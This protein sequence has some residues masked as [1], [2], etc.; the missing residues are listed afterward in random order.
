MTTKDYDRLM[1]DVF[2]RGV[3][4]NGIEFIYTYGEYVKKFE[5]FVTNSPTPNQPRVR[6]IIHKCAGCKIRLD[7]FIESGDFRLAPDA[8]I[9]PLDGDL[10]MTVKEYREKRKEAEQ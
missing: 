2:T 5:G 10:C 4:D 1:K 3:G 9:R 7:E 6:S 8:E